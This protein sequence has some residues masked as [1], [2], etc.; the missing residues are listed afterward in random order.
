[1]WDEGM[2]G[3]GDER[4]HAFDDLEREGD[5]P[6]AGILRFAVWHFLR[7]MRLSLSSMRLSPTGLDAPV[8]GW[9]GCACRPLRRLAVSMTNSTESPLRYLIAGARDAIVASRQS[10]SICLSPSARERS[11]FLRKCRIFSGICCIFLWR[12]RESKIRKW[13]FFIRSAIDFAARPRI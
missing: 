9:V 11:I 5:D 13:S 8:V 3:R 10:R 1:M 6:P 7:S 12:K 2:R 4:T